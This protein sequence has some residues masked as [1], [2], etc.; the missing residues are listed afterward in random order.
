MKF[1]HVILVAQTH[2]TLL[3]VKDEISADTHLQSLLVSDNAIAEDLKVE[4]STIFD[5]N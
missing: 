4:L 3:K 2:T 1:Q 5:L